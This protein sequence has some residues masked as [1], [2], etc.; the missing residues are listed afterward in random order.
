MTHQSE[1][2]Y[3]LN[4][5]FDTVLRNYGNNTAVREGD[6]TVSYY[7]LN[8]DAAVIASFLHSRGLRPGSKVA[9]YMKRSA[10]NIA[11]V[12][13]V[14]KTASCYVPLDTSLNHS[15]ND[16]ILSEV[17]AQCLLYDSSQNPGSLPTHPECYDV[18]Q[19]LGS[20][21]ELSADYRRSRVP[22]DSAY[23]MFTSGSTGKPKGVI[24]PDRAIVRLVKQ[25]NYISLSSTDKIYHI[26]N[27]AFD[28][29]TF[30]IWGAL[31]NGAE[32]VIAKK[33]EVLS[34]EI[35]SA[36]LGKYNITAMFITT[37]LFNLF[38][39]YNSSIFKNL[40]YLIFGG[41]QCNPA[42]VKKVVTEGKPLHLINGYGPTENTTF[43][44]FYEITSAARSYYPIGKVITGTTAVVL[45]DDGK[46][47]EMGE[48]G[49]LYL[50][51]IGLALGYLNNKEL[52]DD[53][54]RQIE[55]NGITNLMYKTGDRV[56]TDENDDFVFLGRKDN[57]VKIR[58][59]RIELNEIATAISTIQGVSDVY[60][61]MREDDI[62]GK[63][64]VAFY[65]MQNGLPH[66]N[67]AELRSILQKVLPYYMIP[68]YF[69][70][71][72]TFPVNP[73][74]KV[75]RNRLLEYF[76]KYIVSLKGKKNDAQVYDAFD[77]LWM[78]FTGKEAIEKDENFF[79]VGG[80]S[81]TA[82]KFILSLN[83]EY[84]LNIPLQIMFELP[85]YSE[86]RE[87]FNRYNKK[88][89]EKSS[90]PSIKKLNEGTVLPPV[91]LVPPG[92]GYQYIFSELAEIFPADRPLYCFESEYEETLIN[93]QLLLEKVAGDFIGLTNQHQVDTI[94][95]CGWSLGALIAFEMAR[96]LNTTSAKKVKLILLD[97]VP[98]VRNTGN[99]QL[100]LL[101]HILFREFYRPAFYKRLYV[102]IRNRI[103]NKRDTT[104]SGNSETG[105][106][107]FV[108]RAVQN[109][110][111]LFID[112]YKK[113][114][115]GNA[116][117]DVLTIW[118]EDAYFSRAELNV[119][120]KLSGYRELC[121][122]NFTQK[123]VRGEH[124][125][126]LRRPFVNEMCR[127][128]VK[129]ISSE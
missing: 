38:A 98:V 112:A 36:D 110:L 41:D 12:L 81:L 75:D 101:I 70:L 74:G 87:R 15:R 59:F 90:G 46:A 24:V 129:F 76:E 29:S 7:Q 115:G 122:G 17:D 54:F 32:L 92:N 33:E 82:I 5:E 127:Q 77:L 120:K 68:G 53:K 79:S 67:E 94:V 80:D 25:T 13:G 104:F 6:F 71:L 69:I 111:R 86:I 103:I 35:F 44:T 3:E 93:E 99:K 100:P 51:G 37:A 21:K 30:E 91:Y 9:L 18:Q 2:L 125:S 39:S 11:A 52:T 61:L 27:L 109:K 49:E 106:H 50:G 113:Y 43:S 108:E 57:Q 56:K 26:S 114:R 55:I 66:Y 128:M 58:G 31:L 34:P 60:L 16:E 1:L 8:A 62:R 42:I 117:C 28:A 121:R 83:N 97:P 64:I 118:A 105:E 124:F 84:S 48:E 47:V 14:V 89:E 107:I 116:E 22:N 20:N 23:I 19:I 45:N 72:E 119:T 78:K 123:Q 65:T 88:D 63:F 10:L 85:V 73:N 102:K 95:L 96:Q 40:K 126:M 4:S